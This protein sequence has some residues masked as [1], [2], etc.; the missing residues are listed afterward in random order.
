MAV[1]CSCRE[2]TNLG[3]SV[4]EEAGSVDG[5]QKFEQMAIVDYSSRVSLYCRLAVTF[6]AYLY[7]QEGNAA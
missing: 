5:V 6:F 4:N 3:I 7:V 2:D 1:C